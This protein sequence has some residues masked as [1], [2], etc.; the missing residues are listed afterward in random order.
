MKSFIDFLTMRK[1]M[2]LSLL[3]LFV[4]LL[5]GDSGMLL[6]DVTVQAPVSDG[7]SAGSEGLTTQQGGQAAAH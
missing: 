5:I 3:C 4:G 6:A 1:G 7:A 2:I